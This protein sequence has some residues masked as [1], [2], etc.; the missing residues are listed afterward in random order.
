MQIPVMIVKISQRGFLFDTYVVTSSILAFY[1][2]NVALFW[3]CSLITFLRLFLL[4]LNGSEFT[5]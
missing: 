5:S 3:L 2:V 4:T 1:S